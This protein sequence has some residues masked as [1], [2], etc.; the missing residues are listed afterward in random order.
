MRDDELIARHSVEVAD[1]EAR[2]EGHRCAIGR[3]C[4]ERLWTVA[5]DARRVHAPR[6]RVHSAGVRVGHR[7]IRDAVA[8][9]IAR[10]RAVLWEERVGSRNR[11]QVHLLGGL[12]LHVRVN[13]EDPRVLVSVGRQYHEHGRA[14][15][16]RDLADTQPMAEPVTIR[17]PAGAG[18]IQRRDRHAELRCNRRLAA[19]VLLNDLE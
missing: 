14:I 5:D 6:Q 11:C 13:H 1:A 17:G 12:H 8:V 3:C 10:F 15:R 4:D 2:A 7:E 18:P 19:H 9:E 16:T